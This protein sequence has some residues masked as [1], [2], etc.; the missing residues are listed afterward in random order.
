MK[1]KK[2][3][4]LSTKLQIMYKPLILIVLLLSSSFGILDASSID[5]AEETIILPP[6]MQ[7][8]D[9]EE[10]PRPQGIK[11]VPFKEVVT[12]VIEKKKG[13]DMTI[14]SYS[15]LSNDN[16][17][18]LIPTSF[19]TKIMNVDNVTSNTP[20]GISSIYYTNEE[21]CVAGIFDDRCILINI[22]FKDITSIGLME[23][24]KIAREI[25]DSVIDDVN[26]VLHTNAKFHSVFAQ[27]PSDT[28]LGDV[29]ILSAV[30]TMDKSSTKNMFNNILGWNLADEIR[31]GGGFFNHMKEWA[32][33]ENSRFTFSMDVDK[34]GLFY[35]V[36]VSVTTHDSEIFLD[37]LSPLDLFDINT[38]NRSTL[39]TN[40]YPLNSIIHL[41]IF[42]EQSLQVERVNAEVIGTAKNAAELKK[43]GWYFIKG[44]SLPDSEIKKLDL[45]YLFGNTNSVGKQKLMLSI[46]PIIKDV[47]PENGGGCLIA[48]ATFGSEIAPQVQFLRELRDNTVLQTE[49]GT[50]FMTGFNQFYYSFS[51][52]IADY[53]RENPAF[54]ETVKIALTPLLTSLTLLQYVDIDSESE[55]LGYGIGVILL[56]IGMYFVAPAILVMKIRKRI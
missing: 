50:I 4:R 6:S 32:N 9:G 43:S 14:A 45:R 55:M 42:S 12:I 11:H 22:P 2:I 49:S 44:E 47:T 15:L 25:G 37:D 7:Q 31:L 48:T 36:Y 26:Q 54:K 5:T 19:E 13:F 28:T 23:G 35:S 20:L 3:N 16:K 29:I 52:A 10:T 18:F 53:E 39:F 17:D 21:R 34:T 27:A 24:Q 51:P 38:L 56:N 40:G 8:L 46:G 1:T 30:Y 41:I 33:N